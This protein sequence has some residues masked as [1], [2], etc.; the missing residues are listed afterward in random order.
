MAMLNNQRVMD[1][2]GYWFLDI[3][4]EMVPALKIGLLMNLYND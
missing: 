2:D 3:D 1:I 4:D